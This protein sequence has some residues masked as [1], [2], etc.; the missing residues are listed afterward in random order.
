MAKAAFA[1]ARARVRW[2]RIA[3]CGSPL[4]DVLIR[5]RPNGSTYASNVRSCGQSWACP[6]CS[7]RQ[8]VKNAAEVRLA[9]STWLATGGLLYLMTLTLRHHPPDGLGASMRSLLSSWRTLQHDHW[10]RDRFSPGKRLIRSVEVTV[11]PNGFNPHLHVLLFVRSGIDRDL[12]DELPERWIRSFSGGSEFRPSKENGATI[13]ECGVEGAAYLSKIQETCV[14]G[15]SN[16]PFDLLDAA[17]NGDRRASAMFYEY[18]DVMARS[19]SVSWSKGLRGELGLS[20]VE[21]CGLVE[22]LD[23]GDN[24]DERDSERPDQKPPDENEHPVVGIFS[25]AEW[26]RLTEEDRQQAVDV[27]AAPSDAMEG[28]EKRTSC[29]KATMS[30][31]PRNRQL[32]C[33]RE[34]DKQ[35]DSLRVVALPGFNRRP[36][37]AWTSL[38]RQGRGCQ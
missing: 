21:L 33:V 22:G 5:R 29:E 4:G 27:L 31:S 15:E 6:S 24:S 10:W 25:A 32:A 13:R 7:A 1:S 30:Y 9:A 3:I 2:G 35:L 28:R 23:L 26:S 36:D 18:A 12:M 20:P 17:S 14:E 37:P 11:G 38:L 19:Q 8:R 16:Y 34:C